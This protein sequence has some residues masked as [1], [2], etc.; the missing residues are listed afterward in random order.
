M[1]HSDVLA[2]DD[3]LALYSGGYQ[4]TCRVASSRVLSR[5]NNIHSDSHSV[6]GHRRGRTSASGPRFV[7]IP[8]F[9]TSE[10]VLC[11]QLEEGDTPKAGD[12][13]ATLT[14][15]TGQKVC[16]KLSLREPIVENVNP[17]VLFG[18]R[19]RPHFVF[20]VPWPAPRP[21]GFT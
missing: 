16:A 15:Q 3:S 14:S 17:P 7:D 18:D 8:P 13:D 9:P 10:S 1:L 6:L 5:E 11:V 21:E 2:D 19:R 4:Q 20:V 12:D